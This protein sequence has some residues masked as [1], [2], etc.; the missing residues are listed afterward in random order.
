M[1][2]K[3]EGMVSLQVTKDEKWV[4]INLIPNQFVN[5]ISD[6]VHVIYVLNFLKLIIVVTTQICWH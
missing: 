6:P 1:F 4:A 5:N 3:L 2:R